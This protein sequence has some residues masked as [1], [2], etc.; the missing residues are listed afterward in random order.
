MSRPEV[1]EYCFLEIIETSPHE[2]ELSSSSYFDSLVSKWFCVECQS[3]GNSNQTRIFFFGEHWKEV[4]SK[5][6][7]WSLL[8]AFVLTVMLELIL[9]DE[10]EKDW[11]KSLLACLHIFVQTQ[12]SKDKLSALICVKK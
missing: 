8:V 4:S 11:W 7:I 9:Q 2:W 3:G 12:T 1:H 10:W 5:E 6:E